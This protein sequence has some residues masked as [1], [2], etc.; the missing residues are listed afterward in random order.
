MEKALNAVAGSFAGDAKNPRAVVYI[1]DGRSRAN[2]LGTETFAK[3]AQKLA[4]AHVPVSSYVLG[5][6]VDRQLPGALAV[7]TGGTVI[8]DADDQARRGGGR[9]VGRRG[10]STVLWPT[11]GRLGRPR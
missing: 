5:A 1:G 4:D 6:R 8:L 3:L 11:L 2:L 10:R 9:P 7:Q